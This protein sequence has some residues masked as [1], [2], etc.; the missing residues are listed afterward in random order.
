MREQSDSYKKW[1][2][3]LPDRHV[4]VDEVN[5]SEHDFPWQHREGEGACAQTLRQC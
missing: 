4:L 3:S 2:M 5:L 1:Q